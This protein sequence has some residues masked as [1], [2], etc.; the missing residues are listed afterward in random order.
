V[1]ITGGT[2]RY[3]NGSGYT[4][5]AVTATGGD[6]PIAPLD[7]TET[8]GGPNVQVRIGGTV[9][10]QQTTTSEELD[11]TDRVESKA[12]VGTP[13]V[14]EMTYQVLENDSTVTRLLVQFDAG[15]ARAAAI[16]QAAPTG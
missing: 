8:S 10:V 5:Q 11:G 9:T 2:I 15:G 14:A 12:S 6:V 16:Y 13:L 4:D 3:W 1:T 7:F